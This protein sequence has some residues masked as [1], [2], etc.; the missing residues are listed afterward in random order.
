M[1]KHLVLLLILPFAYTNGY[2]AQLDN[3]KEFVIKI[4][5]NQGTMHAILYDQTPQ[6]KANF[7]KLT[8]KKFFNGLLFHR[9]SPNFMIQGGD[10]KSRTAKS[11]EPLGNDDL[12]YKIPAEINKS[13]F[14]QKGAIAAARDSNP[15]KES[16]A[17]QFYIV[18]GKVLSDAEL[19]RFKGSQ[20]TKEQRAIYKKNGGSPHLDG[21]YTVFGQVID[22]LPVIEKI[23]SQAKDRR[24][25]PVKDIRMKVSV[26]KLSRKKISKKYG[27]S[28]SP[29]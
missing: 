5:T 12:D 28:F 18:Q 29:N 7:L 21:N 8:Q 19:D 23:A 20:L 9:I 11:G 26:K 4:K 2:S 17:C 13:L 16:S 22:G 14:H 15:K 25:R 24:D 1:T 27:Y 6:H 3:Q 10:P